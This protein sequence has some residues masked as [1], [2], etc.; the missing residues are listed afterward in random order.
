VSAESLLAQLD[1]VR[2]TGPGRWVARCPAH[3]DR[4]ASLGVRELAD[5]RILVHCFAGCAVSEILAAV[6]L[7]FDALFPQ[8]DASH[9][10]KGERRSFPASDVLRAVSFE[11]LLVS[12]AAANL[13]QGAALAEEDRHRLSLAAARL[14]EAASAF[15]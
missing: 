10:V 11:V 6:G 9:A 13:A 7:A 8:Q 5:G 12:I 4:R 14:Q 3:D 2:R 1:A 15:E